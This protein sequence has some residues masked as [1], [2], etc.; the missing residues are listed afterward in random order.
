MNGYD[1]VDEAINPRGE[2]R[3]QDGR[4]KGK[5]MPN[6]RRSGKNV[7]SCPTD[8]GPG[9]GEGEGQGEGKNRK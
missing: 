5:G 6:G 8:E 2:K 7:D 4:G 1:I 3:P 9:K